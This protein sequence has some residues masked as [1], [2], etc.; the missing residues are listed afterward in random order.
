[1][2]MEAVKQERGSLESQLASL[3]K[4]I[5]SLALEVDKHKTKVNIYN[6]YGN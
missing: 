4:Q 1:M 5:S 6:Y 2:E 3:K